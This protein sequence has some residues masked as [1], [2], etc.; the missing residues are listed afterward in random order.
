MQDTVALIRY[1]LPASSI[2]GC[3]IQGAVHDTIHRCNMHVTIKHAS[4]PSMRACCDIYDASVAQH[5]QFADRRVHLSTRRT[6][7]R[8]HLMKI[9]LL[10]LPL[11][12]IF[13]AKLH[14]DGCPN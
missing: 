1:A 6:C 14:H 8:L 13:G 9:H 3:A 11:M 10:G 5:R 2:I 12:R 4:E 7:S